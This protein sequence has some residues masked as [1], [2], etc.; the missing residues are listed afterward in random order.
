V[1]DGR[2]L[3]IVPARRSILLILFLGL[4]LCGWSAGGGFAI[5]QLIAGFNPFLFVW[6]GA[7]AFG[8]LFVGATIAWQLTG[9]ERY[10][11]V[12]ADLEV[13]QQL[14]GL[15]KS[16][17]FR[18]QDIHGLRAADA[19]AF[20]RALAF[21]APLLFWRRWGSVSFRYGART[22]Y[23]APMLDAAEGELIVEALRRQL[24]PGAT[25]R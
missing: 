23:L 14:L 10:A 17:W 13:S 2:Q 4:W 16:W 15:R 3:I 22:I 6:L 24:P 25:A 5:G 18:G 20:T 9:S 1:V 12:G 21:D 7:W 19:P 8:W 11:V